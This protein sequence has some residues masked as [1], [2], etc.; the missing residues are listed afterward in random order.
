MAD[1]SR[2]RLIIRLAAVPEQAPW[3]VRRLDRAGR[4]WL[5]RAYLGAY[6]RPDPR[7][8]ARWERVL[9]IARLAEG[10]EAERAALLG[11]LGR[12]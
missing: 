6:G 8:L 2:S 12:P 10:I 11:A 4:S 3:P 5:L 1:V 7:A 9:L